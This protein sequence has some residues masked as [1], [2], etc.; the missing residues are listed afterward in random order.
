MTWVCVVI[1]L[2]GGCHRKPRPQPPGPSPIGNGQYLITTST[3]DGDASA[4]RRAYGQ[5]NQI[6]RGGYEVVESQVGSSRGSSTRCGASFGVVRC[7]SNQEAP[8]LILVVRCTYAR[9]TEQASP[10]ADDP[11]PMIPDDERQ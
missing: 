5:A 9:S 4:Y 2:A 1:A 3:N 6:C 10:P 7:K 8:D 11:P